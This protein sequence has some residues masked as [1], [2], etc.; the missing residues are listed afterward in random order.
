MCVF[1]LCD[2]RLSLHSYDNDGISYTLIIG[3]TINKVVSLK[4]SA[5]IA[6]SGSHMLDELY[7]SL[8]LD[9]ETQWEKVY[10]IAIDESC[11]PQNP[12]LSGTTYVVA[13]LIGRWIALISPPCRLKR[14]KSAFHHPDPSR[15][16][17][18][19]TSHLGPAER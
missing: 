16:V 11:T 2:A 1:S 15:M 8:G 14:L 6:L 12:L 7:A 18:P 5:L 4:G 9:E 3:D 13:G 17:S 10:F 19:A